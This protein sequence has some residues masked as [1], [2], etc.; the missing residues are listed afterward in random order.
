MNRLPDYVDHL[1]EAAQLACDYTASMSRESFAEDRRTQQAVIFNHHRDG[2]G[3]HQ[4][5]GAIS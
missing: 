3:S 5:P 1:R 2:R 4:D